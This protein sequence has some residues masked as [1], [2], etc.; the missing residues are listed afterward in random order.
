M[1]MMHFYVLLAYDHLR[2]PLA[3]GDY[4]SYTLRFVAILG[5]TIALCLLSRYLVELPATVAQKVR[6]GDTQYGQSR[7]PTPFRLETC[8]ALD[9]CWTH[10]K[11]APR[12]PRA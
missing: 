4:S 3:P 7:R 1:Y 10:F 11:S 6:P 2:G 5:I 8:E 9:L 12:V